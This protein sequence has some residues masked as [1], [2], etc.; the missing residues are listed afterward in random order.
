MQK[1]SSFRTLPK[2]ENF[3]FRT[4]VTDSFL[5]IPDDSNKES[6][7][8]SNGPSDLGGQAAELR[9][10]RQLEQQA[11]SPDKEAQTENNVSKDPHKLPGRFS[12]ST[13]S[14]L[15]RPYHQVNVIQF[16]IISIVMKFV[17]NFS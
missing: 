8:V 4:D 15:N 14:Q 2:I 5:F 9:D 10:S 3:N 6:S 1:T 12:V 7:C 17:N 16:Y 11:K 13:Y